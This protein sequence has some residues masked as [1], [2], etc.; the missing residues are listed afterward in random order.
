VRDRTPAPFTRGAGAATA[1]A[2]ARLDRTL[3]LA[4][5]RT[6]YS[7]LTAQAH[8][9]RPVAGVTS[10]PEV[11]RV[12]D[13]GPEPGPDDVLDGAPTAGA[14]A[15]P[16][17]YDGTASA[18]HAVLAVPSPMADLPVGAGFGTLVHAVLETAD[19]TAPDLTAELAAGVTAEL[20]RHPTPAVDPDALAAALVPVVR[21]PLGPLAGGRALADLAPRDR[22]AEL[23]FELPLAGGDTPGASVVLG[24]LIP[25]LRRHLAPDD[26]LVAYPDRLAPLAHQPLRGYLTG[27]IDAVLRLGDPER[28]VVVDYKTN[29]LGPIGPDGPEPLT[30]A[31]YTPDRLAAA[32]LDA[33]Y[34]LQALLYAAA[35]HRFLRWRLRGY[36]PGRHLGGVLYLFLRGMCGPDGPAV[37]GVPCG[38]FSWRPPAALVTALSDL[39]DGRPA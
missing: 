1:L 30:A 37:D 22:L 9:A 38:V 21:T 12:D 3:D 29:W 7:A 36:N 16:A 26:P 27:S 8:D 2:A 28:Y 13:E 5:R 6:S 18:L 23:D 20:D 35:L 31:H 10:E 17:R 14:A 11:R 25:L 19:L 4:W 39:L 15:D 32:M 34:P 24:D 33:H